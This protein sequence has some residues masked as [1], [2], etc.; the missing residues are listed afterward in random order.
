MVSAKR[1]GCYQFAMLETNR[2][3]VSDFFKL[4]VKFARRPF[5]HN[6]NNAERFGIQ[7]RSAATQDARICYCPIFFNIES[8][9]DTSM[10]IISLCFFRILHI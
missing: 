8:N 7:R 2:E 5:W 9:Y 10:F 1:H 3:S 4:S 6:G